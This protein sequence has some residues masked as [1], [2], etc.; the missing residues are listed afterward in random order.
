MSIDTDLLEDILIYTLN[1]DLLANIFKELIWGIIRYKE[2]NLEDSSERLRGFIEHSHRALYEELIALT[3]NPFYLDDHEKTA[4][5]LYNK[6]RYYVFWN[7][8]IN[9]TQL[10]GE[11]REDY[12]FLATKFHE[13]I[14]YVN[15]SKFLSIIINC[16]KLLLLTGEIMVF[17]ENNP[18]DKLKAI[19][20]TN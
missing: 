13:I 7:L 11:N 2:N 6:L 1:N 19:N 16:I 10:L 9:Q 15:K 18:A 4:K 8:S 20:I 5:N 3:S 12:K 17:I 14:S